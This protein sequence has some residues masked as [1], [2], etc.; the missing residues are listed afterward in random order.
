MVNY[1]YLNLQS[2]SYSGIQNQ[3]HPH[4]SQPYMHVQSISALNAP[5]NDCQGNLVILPPIVTNYIYASSNHTMHYTYT[6]C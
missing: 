2:N 5:H 6:I 4:L 1:I 3:T